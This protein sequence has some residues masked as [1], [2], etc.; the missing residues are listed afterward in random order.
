MVHLTKIYTKTGDDGNTSLANN[1]RVFKHDSVIRAIGAVDEANSAIGMIKGYN[2][3]QIQNDL[4]DIG[5]VL[6]GSKTVQITEDKIRSIELN[7]DS[8][9]ESLPPLHSF[10]LPKGE[11][12][13]ARAIVR[14]A[15]REVWMAYELH[16]EIDNIQIDILCAKYLNRLSDYL[17]VL[18]RYDSGRLGEVLWKPMGQNEK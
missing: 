4:F 6:A 14:R 15:E 16:G 17:F 12:H 7:I 10:V 5:A 18:A 13:N 9:N 3:D 11:I 1:T 8:L 2:L